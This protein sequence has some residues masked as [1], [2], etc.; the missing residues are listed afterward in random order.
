MGVIKRLN[1]EPPLGGP[2]RHN[3]SKSLG[4]G[5]NTT[6]D[7]TTREPE[8]TVEDLFNKGSV[9]VADEQLT[10]VPSRSSPVGGPLLGGK[11]GGANYSPK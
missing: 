1:G 8:D 2:P 11:H 5:V 7:S 6:G 9:V 4:E 10:N 3:S